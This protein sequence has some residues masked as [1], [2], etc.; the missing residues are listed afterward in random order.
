MVAFVRAF[1]SV[2]ALAEKLHT[3]T[4][5]VLAIHATRT[6]NRDYEYTP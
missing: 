5:K 1:R 4:Q 6:H 3:P 2:D